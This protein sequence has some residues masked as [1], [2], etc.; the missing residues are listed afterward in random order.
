VVLTWGASPSSATS[1]YNVYRSNTSG[2]GYTKIS[3]TP[4]SGLTYTDATVASAH[5]YYYVMTAVD[6]IGDESG[7]SAEL[8]EIIP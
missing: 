2:S 6:S 3:S 4:V 5:T 1:G 8:Q 7:F